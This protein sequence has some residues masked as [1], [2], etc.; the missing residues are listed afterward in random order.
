MKTEQE[1][2]DRLKEKIEALRELD[3]KEMQMLKNLAAERKKVLEDFTIKEL[4][5]IP[6]SPNDLTVEEYEVMDQLAEAICELE[7]VLGIEA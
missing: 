3:E 5:G 6:L 2:M 1:I 7:W 4:C